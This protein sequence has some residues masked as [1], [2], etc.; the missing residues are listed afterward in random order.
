MPPIDGLQLIWP[1]VS[2]LCVSS[3]VR[4][5]H[6]RGGQRGLGAG[7]ATA[8]DD[9]VELLGIEHVGRFSM[10]R[11]RPRTCLNFRCR[12]RAARRPRRG[13]ASSRAQ[14]RTKPTSSPQLPP[15]PGFGADAAQVLRDAA[16]AAAPS[17]APRWRSSPAGAR[18]SRASVQLAHGLVDDG[19]RDRRP[20]R[21]WP[22]RAAGCAAACTARAPAARAAS[23][24]PDRL[25][26]H[27]ADQGV[28][29]HRH[30]LDL[31]V[32]RGH[33]RALRRPTRCRVAASKK[34]MLSA[35]EP[36]NSGVVLHHRADHR[37]ASARNPSCD[38]GTPPTSS[39]PLRGAWMPSISFN[40]VVLPQPEGPTMATDSPG[41][42]AQVDAAAAPR[43]RRRRSESSRRALRCARQ[44]R[45]RLR[46]WR[47]T[48][49]SSGAAS[50][51]SARRSPCSRSIFSSTTLSISA[52]TRCANCSL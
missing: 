46:A 39:S 44:C 31:V 21:W 10:R 40:S 26:A 45:P 18:R 43:A 29:A 6:A 24:P 22:R 16:F 4:A 9:D 3:S 34:L 38:N 17:R 47:G 33:A 13:A 5:A 41:S 42:I 19:A 52:L 51:M 11:G 8:D 28:V 50:T 12:R 36:E 27:V 23:G 25:A 32:H 49:S 37:R 35:I 30:R 20:A 1:S 48:P 2:M 14:R 7:M 15:A